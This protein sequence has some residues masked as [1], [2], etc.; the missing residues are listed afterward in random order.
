MTN[1]RTGKAS[2]NGIELHYEDWGDPRHPPVLL[3]CGMSVQLIHW[4]DELVQSLVDQ[5]YRV[6]RFDNREAGLSSRSDVKR[7]PPVVSSFLRYKMRRPVEADYN[8]HTLVADAVGLLDA[9]DIEQAHWVGFSMGGMI[10]QIAAATYPERVHS[11]TSIMSTSNDPDLPAP[12]IKALLALLKPPKNNSDQAIIDA[13]VHTMTTL[14][15]S[16]YPTPRYQLERDAYRVINRARR[17]FAGPMHQMAIFATGG[18]G[19]LLKHVEAPSLIIHGDEDPLVHVEGGKRSAKLIPSARL[20]LIPGMGH[21]FPPQL[22]DTLAEAIG[23][24]I[25]LHHPTINTVAC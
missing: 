11:L 3:V 19:H 10:S 22:N 5:S 7:M 16:G 21:D 4:P 18:F 17:P 25:A 13:I 1:I 6:I 20:M 2:S 8:L 24:H 12:T 9:L 14:Q 23:Q 15:G